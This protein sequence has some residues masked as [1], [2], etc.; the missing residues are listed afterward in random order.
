MLPAT[1]RSAI[2]CG[3]LKSARSTAA[4]GA[5][6]AALA[7]LGQI[8]PV[9]LADPVRPAAVVQALRI[10]GSRVLPGSPAHRALCIV[11]KYRGSRTL[12][13]FLRRNPLF[14]ATVREA[15]AAQ[16]PDMKPAANL[17]KGAAGNFGTK[18]ENFHV[19]NTP[20]PAPDASR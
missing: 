11:L 8:Y 19:H 1:T 9:A 2:R 12:E 4:R 3:C 13:A 15:L 20:A 6:F 17:A 14:V 7:A 10:L 18:R 16:A 5:Y